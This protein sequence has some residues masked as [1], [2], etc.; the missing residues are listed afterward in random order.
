M[1][2]LLIILLI[3]VAGYQILN[4]ERTIRH[5]PGVLIT[6]APEQETISNP[7]EFA[8]KGF[9]I[10]PLAQFQTSARVLSK[11]EYS[12]GIESELSPLDLALGWGSMSDQSV[13]DTLKISQSG[14]WYRWRA[15][16][17]VV[18]RRE[19]ETSSANMHL[20]PASEEIAERLL[21]VSA[22]E[23]IAL[24]GYLIQ[25]EKSNGWKWKSSLTRSDTGAKSCELVWV[26]SFRVLPN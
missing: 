26:E 18:P 13:L 4:M 6:E 22:G 23:L 3:V 11:K 20:V 10:K 15:E 17:L 24:S 7:I 25:A 8:H 14:R 12:R 16:E 9:T 1:R 19:I 5:G 21:D 2:N